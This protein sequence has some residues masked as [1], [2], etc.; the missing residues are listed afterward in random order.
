MKAACALIGPLLTAWTGA[1]LAAQEYV[2]IFVPLARGVPALLYEPVDPGPKA[3][4]AVLVMHPNDDNLTPGP[5]NACVQLARRGYRALCANTATSKT[6]FQSDGDQDRWLL[7]IKPAVAY[8]RA[9]P[10]VNKVILFG[11]SGGG[12]LMASYQNIAENGLGACQ[13]PEKLIRCPDTLA[14]LPPADGVML[15]DASLGTAGSVLVSLDPAVADEDGGQ[16]LSAALDSYRP[17]NGFQSG[18]S[19][20]SAPF[21]ALFLARQ[22]E[23]MNRLIDKARGRLE[24]IDAGNGRFTDDEPFVVPGASPAQNKLNWQDL[25]LMAH[26][27]QP[28]PLLHGDGTI[29]T[30]IVNSVRVAGPAESSTPSL[31]RGALNTTVRHFLS[32]FAVRAAPD[33]GYDAATLR[34]IDYRSSYAI[35]M[36]SV[37][38]ITRPLLQ[39]GMTGSYEFFYAETVREKAKSADKTLAFVEG[40]VHVLT[41]CQPCAVARGL[42]PQAYGDTVKTLYDYIDAWINQPGRFR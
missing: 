27:R 26:T 39:V 16:T 7:N 17:A 12:A 11:H 40:A 37:E 36:N 13:G 18:G 15:I 23:R 33:Y 3:A 9:R 8:L 1:A 21:R 38:G 30:G 6:G 35:T 28:W 31:A 14:G 25:G 41:P 10:E 34:G 32:T 4:V 42:P 22:G 29:T 19:R 20:Y 24:K 2:T 5:A